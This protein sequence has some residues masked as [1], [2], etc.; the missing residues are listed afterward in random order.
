MSLQVN[1]KHLVETAKASLSPSTLNAL[2]PKPLQSLEHTPNPAPKWSFFFVY[3]FLYVLAT[4][5]ELP[6][7]RALRWQPQK[8]LYL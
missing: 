2:R 3:L 4:T 1:N 8:T 5:I 6:E 7:Q